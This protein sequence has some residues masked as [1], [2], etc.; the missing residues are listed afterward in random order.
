MR[1]KNTRQGRIPATKGLGAA[2][3][4]AYTPQ[5]YHAVIPRPWSRQMNEKLIT[6]VKRMGLAAFLFFFLKGLAWLAVFYFGWKM[7]E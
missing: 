3:Q 1:Q 5:R 6:Y 4:A 7:F 2:R